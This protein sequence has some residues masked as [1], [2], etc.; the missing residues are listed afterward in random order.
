MVLLLGS[1]AERGTGIGDLLAR[2]GIKK[3]VHWAVAK[4]LAFPLV[5]VRSMVHHRS[6]RDFM[7]SRMFPEYCL[8]LPIILA[9]TVED[10]RW[11]H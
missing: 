4:H 5:E 2:S 10:A 1:G 3:L 8:I 9:S 11:W 6:R 7:T